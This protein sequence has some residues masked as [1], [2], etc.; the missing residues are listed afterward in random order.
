MSGSRT[1]QPVRHQPTSAASRQ[2][3]RNPRPRAGRVG[4]P[5]EHRQAVRE[6]VVSHRRRVVP[7]LH[8][9]RLSFAARACVHAGM[10][11]RRRARP[12]AC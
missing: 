3:L 8:V 5:V 7:N 2:C 10:K 4:E 11:D 1:R 9:R 12:V 6:V